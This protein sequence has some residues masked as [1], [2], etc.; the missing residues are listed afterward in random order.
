[1]PATL[2]GETVKLTCFVWVANPAPEITWTDPH[3][4]TLPHSNGKVVLPKVKR[5]QGGTYTCK[6]FNGIGKPIV[7]S[8][9]LSVYCKSMLL[10]SCSFHISLVK[11]VRAIEI[12]L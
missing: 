11:E 10:R 6:A 3:N 12:L 9:L 2:E 7:L 4:K 8:R 5:E 1:M